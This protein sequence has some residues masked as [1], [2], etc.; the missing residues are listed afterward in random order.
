M[1]WNNN[2]LEILTDILESVSDTDNNITIIGWQRIV[3]DDGNV[4]EVN[5]IQLVIPPKPE[6]ESEASNIVDV[7]EDDDDD[8]DDLDDRV[9]P[10]DEINEIREVFEPFASV[11][12]PGSVTLESYD[13]DNKQTHLL[14]LDKDELFFKA[15]DF[16]IYNKTSTATSEEV[17]KFIAN[18]KPGNLGKPS[19]LKYDQEGK[20]LVNESHIRP[21]LLGGVIDFYEATDD[22][23]LKAP[24]I[25]ATISQ[26]FERAQ[27]PKELSEAFNKAYPKY[28]WRTLTDPGD[29]Y[30]T[31]D[32]TLTL[33]YDN[34]DLDEN[35]DVSWLVYGVKR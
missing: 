31:R 22:M 23:L 26:Q 21:Q 19:V 10:H 3:G 14:Y 32:V 16:A 5:T 4:K 25:I 27:I 20:L 1:A 34:F 35:S 30:L 15:E 7:D 11:G 8:D 28:Q 17:S 18:I 24:K 9:L 29:V 33:T 13:Q 2:K 12:I 6:T